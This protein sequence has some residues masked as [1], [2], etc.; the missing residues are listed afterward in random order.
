[1]LSYPYV[2]VASVRLSLRAATSLNACSSEA[3]EQLSSFGTLAAAR[4]VGKPGDRGNLGTDGKPGDRRDVHQFLRPYRESSF[5]NL[6]RKHHHRQSSR[7]RLIRWK[8]GDRRDV[9][10]FL[11]PYRE[12]SFKHLVRKHRHRQSSRRRLIRWRHGPVRSGCRR[13]CSASCYA[14]W[15]RPATYCYQRRRPCHLSCVAPTVFGSAWTWCAG[16][17]PDVQ[18]CASHR[19]TAR[20]GRDGAGSE[21]GAR[22]ICDLLECTTVVQRSCL[23][24][25]ILFVSAGRQ[26]FV[27]S[28]AVCGI[29][30]GASEDG[31]DSRAV[32][33]VE[34]GGAL[35]QSGC[36]RHA[37]DGAVGKALDRDRVGAVPGGGRI[38]V[39][40]RR[41]APMHPHGASAGRHQVRRRVG[42]NHVA[43]TCAAEGRPPQ[44]SS[45]PLAADECQLRG[46]IK[47]G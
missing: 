33:M 14:A 1:M 32:E 4:F 10:Q 34:R 23:A 13:R 39:G 46:L 6:V 3:L 30:S 26:S 41:P 11:R 44:E 15:Q 7:R 12:S 19:R 16:L 2:I 21:A 47:N 25:E 40:G 45:G 31:G 36:R 28:A 5:K 38:G 22:T 18:S 37:A 43:P 17:L 29:K 20:T 8:P 35:R 9:H 27:G 42:K 24:G